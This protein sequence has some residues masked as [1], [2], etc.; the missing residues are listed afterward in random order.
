M[1]EKLLNE[2]V[3]A[4]EVGL[5]AHLKACEKKHERNFRLQLVILAAI[6]GILAKQFGWM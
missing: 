3:V 2:R 4:L 1:T 5:A 6:T